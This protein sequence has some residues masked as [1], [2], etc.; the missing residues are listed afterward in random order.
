[1]P[2]FST[3]ARCYIRAKV[4]SSLPIVIELGVEKKEWIGNVQ[5]QAKLETL[6]QSLNH[7]IESY[8]SKKKN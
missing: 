8:T 7:S 5:S 1:M 2:S 3:L 4:I 6:Q